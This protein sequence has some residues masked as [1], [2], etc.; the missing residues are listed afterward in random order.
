MIVG[1]RAWMHVASAVALL[2]QTHSTFHRT[3]RRAS[4]PVVLVHEAH[5]FLTCRR[6]D[7]LAS[8]CPPAPSPPSPPLHKAAGPAPVT[9]PALALTG[10]RCSNPSGHPPCQHRR[11]PIVSGLLAPRPARQVVVT[12][13]QCLP[14]PGRLTGTLQ[15]LTLSCCH[16]IL[17]VPLALPTRRHG[18]GGAAHRSE[19]QRAGH[20]RL[21]SGRHVAAGHQPLSDGL[22][23]GLRG[24]P[25][26]L[27]RRRGR[28]HQ[29]LFK[30]GNVVL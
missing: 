5:R 28:A 9:A 14:E 17:W 8:A 29:T 25:G 27:V 11:L 10:V 12:G 13:Q 16:I 4:C 7:L 30:V 1:C 22:V 24:T 26:C 6:P 18:G 23:A 19:G 15:C 20:R 3:W 2:R 21:P